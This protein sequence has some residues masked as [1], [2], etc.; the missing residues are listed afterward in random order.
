MYEWI[1]II[2]AL[3]VMTVSFW[4]IFQK[5]GRPGWYSLIPL[6]NIVAM[7]DVAGRSP[8]LAVFIVVV[9]RIFTMLMPGLGL[10]SEIIA[11]VTF[12]LVMISYGFAEKF[13]TGLMFSIGTILLPVVFYPILAFGNYEYEEEEYG[14]YDED[15]D[16]V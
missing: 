10:E 14:Y 11:D 7:L 12:L 13:K 5:A 16:N 1:F 6:W 2:V 9:S 15:S 3:L 8:W 4:F